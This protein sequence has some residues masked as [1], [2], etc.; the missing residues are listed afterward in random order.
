[1]NQLARQHHQMPLSADETCRGTQWLIVNPDITQAAGGQCCWR[2]RWTLKSLVIVPS[3]AAEHLSS[4]SCSISCGACHPVLEG[5]FCRT[6]DI[7][8]E[9]ELGHTF[10]R[11]MPLLMLCSVSR[12]ARRAMLEEKLVPQLVSWLDM[13]D[14]AGRQR[15]YHGA[16]LQVARLL[17]PLLRR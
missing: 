16:V 7:A 6:W 15:P 3:A 9:Q 5:S 8:C 2:M 12:G 13:R 1:M 4:L 11:C 10:T 14:S 17:S